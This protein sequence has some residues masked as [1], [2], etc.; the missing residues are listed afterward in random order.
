MALNDKPDP[1]NP[2]RAAAFVGIGLVLYALLFAAAEMLVRYN[3][4]GNPVYRIIATERTHHDW[5][6]LGASHAMPLDFQDFGARIE[7]QT[8]RTVLNLAAPGT[9]PLYHRFLAERYFAEHGA[10]GVLV[11]VDSFGFYSAKWNEDRFGDRDLLSRTPL[12]PTTLEMFLRYLPRGVDPRAWLD[13]ASGF[14]KINNQDRFEPDQWEAEARFDRAPRPSNVADNDRI[15]YLY[16]Q[17]VVPARV[18]RY[19]GDLLALIRAA[20]GA[21]AEVVVAKLPLPDRFRVL[22]PHEDEFDR[23]LFETMREEGVAVRDFSGVLPEPRYY[24]D[25]DHLN[26]EGA[27]LFLAQHLGPLLREEMD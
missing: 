17:G 20:R 4:D 14:S 15:E 6:V 11:V 2:A 19:M 26:E 27:R 18:E 1:L 23:V 8:G 16:P 9:G 13:Y 7:A 21:G 24:F 25:P 22:L 10:D 12:D 5:I 3:G